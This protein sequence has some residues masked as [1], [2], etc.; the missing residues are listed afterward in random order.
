ME[1]E[2]R[3]KRKA[4]RF[5]TGRATVAIQDFGCRGQ[6]CRGELIDCSETGVGLFTPYRV[7]PHAIL[8]LRACQDIVPTGAQPSP[9]DS[10]RFHM[11]S[12]EVRWCREEFWAD[13]R[14]RF[15]IGVARLLPAV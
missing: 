12:V 8:V 2:C 13:G 3:E 1:A 11:L 15:R 9:A 5:A 14:P 6:H 10:V 7:R 4:E